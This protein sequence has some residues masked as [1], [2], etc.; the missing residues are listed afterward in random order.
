M[1]GQLTDGREEADI[2]SEPSAFTGAKQR[3]SMRT[4]FRSEK[5]AATLFVTWTSR[6]E[7]LR[8]TQKV[9]LVMQEGVRAGGG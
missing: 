4:V 5:P 8:K 9:L 6:R 1:R 7:F 2:F 3:Q